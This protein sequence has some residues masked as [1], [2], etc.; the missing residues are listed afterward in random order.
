MPLIVA[1]HEC[2]RICPELHL[3]LDELVE[4]FLMGGSIE[5]KHLASQLSHVIEARLRRLGPRVLLVEDPQLLYVAGI[6]AR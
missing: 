2:I 1:M 5:S 4:C 6:A 3:R